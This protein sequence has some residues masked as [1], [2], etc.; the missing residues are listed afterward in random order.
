MTTEERLR[1][2]F[3]LDTIAKQR[4]SERRG[5]AYALWAIGV[6]VML[7]MSTPLGLLIVLIACLL[8]VINLG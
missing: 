5:F 1:V 7:F 6:G 2:Q 3:V 4:R 8:F